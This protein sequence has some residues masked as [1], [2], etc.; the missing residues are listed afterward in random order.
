VQS[1]LSAKMASLLLMQ[2][3]FGMYIFAIGDG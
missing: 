1:T 3:T 2:L